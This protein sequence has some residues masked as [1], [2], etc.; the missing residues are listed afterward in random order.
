[1][2]ADEFMDDVADGLAERDE[3]MLEVDHVDDVSCLDCE[4]DEP[5]HVCT[6]SKKL[7]G[8]HCNH[9]W[10]HHACCWCKESWGGVEEVDGESAF[11]HDD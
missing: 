9:G 11:D 4:Q 3:Y 8:H 5:D 2:T 10:T 6:K 1:M 7:C